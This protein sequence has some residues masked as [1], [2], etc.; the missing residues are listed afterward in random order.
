MDTVE[1]NIFEEFSQRLADRFAA[2]MTG[3]TNPCV[4]LIDIESIGGEAE[5]LGDMKQAIDAKKAEGYIFITN[6]EDYAYSCG[7][8]LFLMGDIRLCSDTARF[9]FHSAGIDIKNE[10]LIQQD[11]MELAL[12]VESANAILDSIVEE[13]TTVAPEILQVLMKNDNFL[14]KEDLIYLGFMEREYELI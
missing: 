10:R 9:L 14:S 2:F 12:L 4:V 3:L 8:F 7:L 13:N 6:V 5:I 1:F 11:I